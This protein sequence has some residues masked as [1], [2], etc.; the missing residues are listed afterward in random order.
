MTTRRQF[1]FLIKVSFTILIFWALYH[2][3]QLQFGLM[4]KFLDHPWLTLL[5]MGLCYLMVC[6]HTWRWYRLNAAQNISL[7]LTKT[8]L[9]AFVA[10]A[11]NNVLPGSVGGDFF[12]MY[13]VLKKFPTQKSNAL[14]AIFV[15]RLTGLLG[16]IVM[17]CIAA[18]FYLDTFEHNATLYYL[19]MACVVICICSL[20][21]FFVLAILLSDRIGLVDWLEKKI[22]GYR[23]AAPCISLLRAVYI[24]RS[25]KWIIAESLVMS[26][27][28]QLILLAIVV[29]IG[30]AMSLPPL[31]MGVY[32]MALVIGQ[33]ANLIPLTPGG[34]GVGEAAFANII[35]LFNP[36]TAAYATVFFALRVLSTLAYLPGVFIGIFGFHVFDHQ[37]EQLEAPAMDQVV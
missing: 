5:I 3:S 36:S 24:Y 30:D 9:P 1:I 35:Y 32:I 12:R 8:F 37:A 22:Q 13:F 18:P 14:L 7:P 4:T 15:D 27:G 26:I 17:A 11:F 21:T 2:H 28:T 29:I 20:I 10:I 6:F 23:Y 19:L 31:T 33:V 16:I 25:A 34:L